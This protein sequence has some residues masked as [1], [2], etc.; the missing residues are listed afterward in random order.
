MPNSLT[1]NA[2]LRLGP[3]VL[4]TLV[5]HYFDRLKKENEQRSNFATQLHQDELLYHEAFN[6]VKGF[7]QASTYHT[8][9]EVQAFSNNRT[10]SPPWVRVMHVLVAVSCC[11]EAATYVVQALGGE[12]FAKR[13]VGGT[14]WWQVRGVQGVDAEW[15]TARKD[16][17]EAKKRSRVKHK[18]NSNP[19]IPATES[20]TQTSDGPSASSSS[21]INAYKEEMDEMRCILYAHGGGYYFGSVDQE[22]YSIQRHARKINGRVFA[23]NY[24]LAPQYPFPCALQD[25]L[26]TYLYLIKPPSDASHRPVQPAHLVVAGDSAGGGLTLALLQVLRDTGLPLPAG[27]ILISPWCDLTHSFPSIHTNTATDV[28]PL[29]G[30]SFHKP[31]PLWPP[32]SD[33]MTHKVHSKLRKRIHQMVRFEGK[34]K[35]DTEASS[36]ASIIKD[37]SGSFIGVNG[38]AGTPASS[39][40]PVDVDATTPPPPRG[41]TEDQTIRL[42]GETGELLIIEEQVH[43]YTQNSLIGHPLISSAFSYLGGL[44]PLFFIASDKE[45]LRDEIIYTAHKAANPSGFPLKDEARS[46]YPPLKGIEARHH[47]PTAVHLQVYDDTAHVLPVLFSFTTPGKFCYRAIA[48]FTKHV[49]GMNPSRSSTGQTV[50]P[51]STLPSQTFASS[52]SRLSRALSTPEFLNRIQGS[53]GGL[54]DSPVPSPSLPTLF[55]SPFSRSDIPSRAKSLQVSKSASDRALSE[56]TLQPRIS[57]NVN[58]VDA[59]ITLSMSDSPHRTQ[60]FAGESA[61]YCND[62]G[63]PSW[64]EGM[65]CE[66]VSTRGVI[67]PLEPELGL[68]ALRFHQTILETLP[69]LAVRRYLDGK[70]TFDTKF[71]KDLRAVQKQRDRNLELS[72]KDVM[73]NI[74]QLQGLKS[75]QNRNGKG[76]ARD[77]TKGVKEGLEAAS[78]SWS[79]AWALDADERP[80]PSSII[81]RRDTA[82]ARRLAQIADQAALQEHSQ[83]SANSLW[84]VVINFLTDREHKHADSTISDGDHQPSSPLQ[85]RKSL[86]TSLRSRERE[87]NKPEPST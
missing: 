25:L 83:M 74:A 18:E 19:D 7:L 20:Y 16:H 84:A 58:V 48:S 26:A 53:P 44:P 22:R 70:A 75:S 2:G 30:L 35:H 67:R 46:L 38:D 24:R 50:S 8:V 78:A 32:P 31:S 72:K 37:S 81:S 59:E 62:Q 13:L 49:T 3:V 4:E 85:K 68:D 47:S 28:I 45:V 80:P 65:I 64:K 56:S 73:K 15:I 54:P 69:E 52:L 34:E 17:V 61:V 21:G 66:R 36:N 12:E 29:Y 55:R 33:E 5:K 41:K 39:E 60:R 40:M 63:V 87:V 86:F 23:V 11:D 76:K 42:Q 77:T 10:P 1:R 82:E 57:D 9:E 43:L 14:K 6:I 71:A 79:W 27:G 51:S